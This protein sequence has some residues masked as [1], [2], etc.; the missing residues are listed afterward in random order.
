MLALDLGALGGKSR[1][2]SLKQ[3]LIWSAVWI[4]LALI[5][6]AGSYFWSGGGKALQFLTSYLVELS[7]S[8]DNLFAF[9]LV[10]GYFEV[11]AEYRHKALFWGIIGALIMRAVL[12]TAGVTLIAKF[13]WITYV[14]GGLLV[15]S[16]IKMTLQRDKAIHPDRN[17]VLKFVPTFHGGHAGLRRWAVF[18][19]KGRTNSRLAAVCRCVNPGKH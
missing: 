19:E 11:P 7:L 10:F 14:F 12:I 3:A 17:P 8:V 16:G 2:P 15:A 5:F 13:H 6:N 4:A 18:C 1:E 9:L